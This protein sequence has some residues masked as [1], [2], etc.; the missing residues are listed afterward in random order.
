MNSDDNSSL[1]SWL[2]LG[3]YSLLVAMATSLALAF[4]ALVMAHQV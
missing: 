1:L 2:S 4:L 3:F